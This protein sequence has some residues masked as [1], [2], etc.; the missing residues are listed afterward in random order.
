MGELLIVFIWLV[1]AL[2]AIYFAFWALEKATW[3]VPV[4][5]I[6]TTLLVA[7]V[8]ILCLAAFITALQRA[9]LLGAF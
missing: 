8:V 3:P 5:T 2:I 9:G 4:R 6:A 1:V 7:F